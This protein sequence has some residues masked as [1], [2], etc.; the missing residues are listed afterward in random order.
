MH[1]DVT[2]EGR[3]NYTYI[4]QN[5]ECKEEAYGIRTAARYLPL[6]LV[7]Y[8]QNAYNIVTKDQPKKEVSTGRE[9][10]M[11]ILQRLL[12]LKQSSLDDDGL[13]DYLIDL[14]NKCRAKNIKKRE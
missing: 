13:R 4:L 6:D 10:W 11:A 1:A 5:G 12:I 14:R 9:A 2:E 3:F 7:D 8:A